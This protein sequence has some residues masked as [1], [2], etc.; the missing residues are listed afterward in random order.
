MRAVLALASLALTA[1]ALALTGHAPPATGWAARPIVMI[2]DGRGDLCSGTSLAHELVLTAAH[3]VE[4]QQ[5]YKIR[6]YQMAFLA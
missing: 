6:A 4:R 3:C 2:V 1:P 5:T